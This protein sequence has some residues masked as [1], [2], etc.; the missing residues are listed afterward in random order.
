MN[1]EARH[2]M[3][4]HDFIKPKHLT[5]VL[6]QINAGLEDLVSVIIEPEFYHG[7]MEHYSMPDYFFK[8]S[9][10]YIFPGEMKSSKKRA[11]KAFK[12]LVSGKLYCEE[13]F[14]YTPN[15]GLFIAKE[16]GGYFTRFYDI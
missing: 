1:A 10:G 11:G 16:H 4:L 2:L 9:S 14:D 8:L 12:Q 5:P 15:L 7:S 13:M 6:K 3:Y